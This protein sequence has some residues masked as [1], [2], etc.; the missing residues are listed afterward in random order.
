[1]PRRGSGHALLRYHPDNLYFLTDIWLEIVKYIIWPG[2]EED[3]LV[4]DKREEFPKNNF[5]KND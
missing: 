1:M 2:L 3:A 4:A 5:V